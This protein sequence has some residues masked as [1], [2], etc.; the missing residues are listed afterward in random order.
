MDFKKIALYVATL[1]VGF[2]LWTTWLRDNPPQAASA[3]TSEQSNPTS[4]S[5]NYVPQS[6]SPQPAGADAAHAHGQSQ[7]AANVASQGR[8]LKVQ[9]DLMKVRINPLGGNIISAKLLK[10]P[11]SVQQKN[12][13]ISILSS[14]PVPYVAQSGITHAGGQPITYTTTKSQYRLA[15]NQKA[16]VVTLTGRQGKLQVKKI[17]SFIRG[18]YAIGLQQQVKNTGQAAWSGS[19][20]QQFLRQH[21]K[22]SHWMSNRGYNGGAISTPDK[23]YD[24]L[25]Y[26]N[27]NE[28]NLGRSIPGGWVAMQQH[29]FLSTWLPAKNTRNYFYT[30]VNSTASGA[31]SYTLGYVSPAVQLASGQVATHKATLYVGPEIESRL[32]RLDPN[33]HLTVNYGF[34]SFFA[35]IIFWLMN[36]I[37]HFI[38]NWGWSI[39]LVTVVIKLLLY[40]PSA[41]SYKSMARMRDM[42]PRMKVLQER[43]ADDRQ[44]LSKATMELYKREKVNPMGGCLP[45]LVQLPIFIAF[46]SLLVETVQLRQAPFM[47]WIHDLTVHDPYYILPVLMG[48][49]MFLQQK[50][51]PPPP[52]PAQAKMMMF[53]PVIFTVFFLHFPVGLVIYYLTNNLLSVAQQWYVMKTFDP[54]VDEMARRKKSKQAKRGRFT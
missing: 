25:T 42:A 14:G 28:A 40:Y 53:L 37:H 22:Q 51:S 21:Q 1:M 32:N 47:F 16:L 24:K 35:E 4:S 33:L 3:A 34:L 41:I 39:I 44:A 19:F 50:L 11:I 29:Y 9:T 45:M 10:Y 49:S 23:P 8:V 46:Y 31:S 7:Q 13:P 5:G 20:Y 26:K 6:Y 48:A 38:G 54:K 2:M 43:H 18:R 27:M 17:Y 36:W 30:R 15:D 12:I 52:D